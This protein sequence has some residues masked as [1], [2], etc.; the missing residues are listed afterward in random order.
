MQ[1]KKK[2]P[3]RNMVAPETAD[4]VRED[5]T[6]GSKNVKGGPKMQRPCDVP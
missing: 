3:L 4:A 1:A 6:K 5:R 2:P